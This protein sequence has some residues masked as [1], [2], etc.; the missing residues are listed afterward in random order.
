MAHP[1]QSAVVSV[2]LDRHGRTYAEEAGIRVG[3]GTPAPL[4]QLLVLT[5]LMSARIRAR[6][7]VGAA[8]ALFEAGWTTTSK[9][10][11]STWEQ[12]TKVLNQSGYARYDESTSRML[13]ATVDHLLDAYGGDLRKLRDE[14]ERHPRRERELLKRCKGIGDTGVD[15]FFREVQIV[16][17]ELDPFADDRATSSAAALGLPDTPQALRQLAG[18][19]EAHVRLVSA[20]VRSSLAKDTDE[21]LDIA[22]NR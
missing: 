8:R 12:R 14:A 17:D 18:D 22:A 19:V 1:T 16:W 2:L 13:G 21:V 4:F 20:A 9:M 3:Q 11:D 6:V 7:A 15:L 5:L 10:A